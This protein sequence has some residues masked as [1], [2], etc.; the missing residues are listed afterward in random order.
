MFELIISS[1]LVIQSISV[2]IGSIFVLQRVLNASTVGLRLAFILFPIA[3]SLEILDLFEIG[4]SHLSSIVLNWSILLIMLWIW[5]QRKMFCKLN[6]LMI[7][8]D[9]NT[10]YSIGT[11]IV[12]IISS[13]A[14]W[15]LHRIK[16][17]EILMVVKDKS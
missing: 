15:V 5:S 14:F 7:S 6:E 8:T 3:A 10:K 12:A 2:F 11:E 4:S 17:K 1:V 13:I 9:N 16:N